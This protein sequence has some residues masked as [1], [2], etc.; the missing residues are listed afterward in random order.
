MASEIVRHAARAFF[1]ASEIVSHA[2]KAFFTA[3]EITRQGAGGVI[4]TLRKTSIAAVVSISD[5]HWIVHRIHPS[6]LW[7]G[8]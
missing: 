7:F 2:A 4:E 3:F 5:I 8:T 1:M 6:F